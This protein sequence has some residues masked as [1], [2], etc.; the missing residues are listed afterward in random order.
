MVEP[1][2]PEATPVS[3]GA[4]VDAEKRDS[5]FELWVA[6][7]LGIVSVGIA[8]A[9]FQA[10][11]YDS[12]MADAYQEGNRLATEAESSYLEG[13][14][15]YVQDAQLWNRLT[16]LAI[17]QDSVDPAVAADAT[18]TYEVLFF[19]SVSEAMNE[20]ILWADEQNTANPDEYFSPLDSDAYL[21]TLFG[22][23]GS[24][25]ADADA[26]GARGDEY[27]TLSD[28]LTL[29]T[30]LMSISLFL[31]GIAAVVR[32]YRVRLML[33]IGGSVVFAV[34]AVLTLLVPFIWF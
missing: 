10:A 17:Q 3:T 25:K 31:V 29:Y 23:Y 28:R 2:P 33:L 1:D 34:A 13:N 9:S 7:V 5:R 32:T 30:V 24:L 16:E 26:A 11:L 8:Y 19:Q 22:G 14:Q 4:P 12:Q 21:E 18:N 20:A 6:I 15:Q 27:N